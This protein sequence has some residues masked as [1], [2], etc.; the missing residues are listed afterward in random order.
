[1]RGATRHSLWLALGVMTVA[2]AGCGTGG[3]YEAGI[4]VGDGGY[5]E[6]PYY[7]DDPCCYGKVD[8]DNFSPEFV[9]TF[10]LSPAATGAW[11]DEL[12][13]YPLAPGEGALV[14]DFVEDAYDAEADLEFGDL[15]Q[16]FGVPVPADELT[17]FEVF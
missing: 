16:W 5:Y 11:S 2:V 4:A 6:D 9:D 13:G 7:Y 8:V 10:F 17:V 3:F 14:G 1:M 15:V 12:L